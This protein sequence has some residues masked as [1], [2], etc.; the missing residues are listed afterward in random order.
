MEAPRRGQ[1]VLNFKNRN[2]F[3]A[4]PILVRPTDTFYPCQ[5]TILDDNQTETRNDGNQSSLFSSLGPT[6]PSVRTA[7]KETMTVCFVRLTRHLPPPAKL[8]IIGQTV[9][10]TEPH[11]AR[12]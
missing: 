1:A 7:L 8:F 12:F 3:L 11:K 2:V 4:H 5:D 9:G 10:I 6:L